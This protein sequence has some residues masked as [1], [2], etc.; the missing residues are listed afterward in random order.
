MSAD[1]LGLVG[2]GGENQQDSVRTITILRAP[3]HF[4][5]EHPHIGPVERYF[6][7]G[8]AVIQQHA[9]GAM[10][11]DQE[12]LALLVRVFAAQFHRGHIEHD[13]ISCGRERH[14]GRDFPYGQGTPRIGDAPHKEQGT[15]AHPQTDLR[16]ARQMTKSMNVNVLGIGFPPGA[17]AIKIA[18]DLGG[19]AFH[20]GIRRDRSKYDGTC[21]NPRALAN[22]HIGTNYGGGVQACIRMNYNPITSK[23]HPRTHCYVPGNQCAVRDNTVTS[24]SVHAG[25]PLCPPAAL[26]S[27]TKSK[28][29]DLVVQINYVGNALQSQTHY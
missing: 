8:L 3:D 10:Q 14:L 6:T 11:A 2:A 24:S 17:F 27:S 26:M 5:H 15:F 20:N 4:R 22:R 19:V 13:K 7:T 1:I 28:P 12:L 21:P 18:D 29:L 23:N 9:A 25:S 16:R